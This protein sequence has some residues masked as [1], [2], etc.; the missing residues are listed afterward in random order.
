M[1][2]SVLFSSAKLL[3]LPIVVPKTRRPRCL[4]DQC[5]ERCGDSLVLWPCR[6]RRRVGGRRRLVLRRRGKVIKKMTR[7]GIDYDC[8]VR[9]SIQFVLRMTTSP[10]APR[11]K[12]YIYI[13]SILGSF[14]V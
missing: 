6:G 9:V 4:A 2:V 5:P 10:T 3:I 11:N 12:H 8:R 1:S 7:N 14:V 13:C